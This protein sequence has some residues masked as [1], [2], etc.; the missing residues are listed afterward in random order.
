MKKIYLRGLSPCENH[1][2][3]KNPET[4]VPGFYGE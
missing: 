3:K 2:A 1:I 4:E